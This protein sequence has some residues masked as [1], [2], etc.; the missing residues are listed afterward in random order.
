MTDPVLVDDGV[1]LD[2]VLVAKAASLP[3]V[4]FST[5]SSCAMLADPVRLAS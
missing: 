2:T 4:N 3:S 1:S 5:L